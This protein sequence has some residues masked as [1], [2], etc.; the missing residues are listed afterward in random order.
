[1][2][3]GLSFFTLAFALLTLAA[4]MD[5]RGAGGS[6]GQASGPPT[7]VGPPDGEAYN[8]PQHSM[9]FGPL[10]QPAPGANKHI[11]CITQDIHT[12]P[13]TPHTAHGDRS[14]PGYYADEVT[15]DRSVREMPNFCYSGPNCMWSV[16]ACYENSA[17]S[18]SCEYAEPFRHVR[19]TQ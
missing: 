3:I 16:A 2:K 10:W 7:L 12:C 9:F 17:H 11:L 1:M 13:E 6:G 18:W 14:T 5:G 19:I 8:D 15:A 4:C